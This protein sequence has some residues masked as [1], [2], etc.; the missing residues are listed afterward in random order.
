MAGEDAEPVWW[1]APLRFLFEMLAGTAIFLIVGSSALFLNWLVE[2]LQ[3]HGI[4][5]AIVYGLEFA[6]YTL[7]LTDLVLFCRFA[8][9]TGRRTWGAL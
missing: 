1:K 8:Y 7:F 9:V 6:E 5:Q 4:N 3:A 2:F